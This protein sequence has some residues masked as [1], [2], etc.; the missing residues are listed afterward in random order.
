MW[1][2]IDGRD[3]AI[4]ILPLESH[5][6]EFNDNQSSFQHQFHCI[7]AYQIKLVS[8]LFVLLN[9]KATLIW[10]KLRAREGEMI[11]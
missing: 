8:Q 4:S 3:A 10:R 11:K 1:N 2:G 9:T 7:L 5:V 6:W